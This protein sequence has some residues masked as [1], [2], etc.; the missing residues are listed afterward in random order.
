MSVTS[1]DVERVVLEMEGGEFEVGM[2]AAV[3]EVERE[4]WATNDGY[5]TLVWVTLLKMI[6]QRSSWMSGQ[7]EMTPSV[8]WKEIP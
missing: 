3:E 4:F 8:V 2:L 5:S 1:T 6:W 7:S